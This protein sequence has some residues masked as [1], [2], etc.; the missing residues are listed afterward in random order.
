MTAVECWGTGLTGAWKEVGLKYA[1]PVTLEQNLTVVL[2][3]LTEAVRASTITFVHFWIEQTKDEVMEERQLW[4][5]SRVGE[6]LMQVGGGNM[7]WLAVFVALRPKRMCSSHIAHGRP[8][9]SL[10]T[11]FTF[12]APRTSMPF[13]DSHLGLCT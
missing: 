10:R 11:S 1:P 5:A 4:V 7:S 8:L 12:S 9:G 6:E 2:K 3:V 13:L